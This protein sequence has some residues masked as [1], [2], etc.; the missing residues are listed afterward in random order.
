MPEVLISFNWA[1]QIRCF[2]SDPETNPELKQERLPVFDL[3]FAVFSL[4]YANNAQTCKLTIIIPKTYNH[5]NQ[6]IH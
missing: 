3:T 5:N 2:P 4:K 1:P 6:I